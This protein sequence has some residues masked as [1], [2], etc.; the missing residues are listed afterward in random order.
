MRANHA[1]ASFLLAGLLGGL[2]FTLAVDPAWGQG[3]A[4][5]PKDA[6]KEKGRPEAK[7]GADKRDDPGP[8]K[9]AKAAA[10]DARPEAKGAAPREAPRAGE[11]K[12]AAK[13][14]PESAK[15][16]PKGGRDGA[17]DAPPAKRDA[18]DSRDKRAPEQGRDAGRDAGKAAGQAARDKAK[19]A[20]EASRDRR[21]ADRPEARRE[22]RQ[23]TN[24]DS[25]RSDVRRQ[26]REF[27]AED[28]RPADIGLW[29]NASDQGLVISDVASSGAIAR[30]GF[31]EGDRIVSVNG[32]RIT[33]EADFVRYLFAPDIR[34]QRVKVIVFR[35]GREEIVY[36][37]PVVLVQQYSVV[38]ADPLEEFG[39]VIDDRY[40][41]RLIV[42]KVIPRSP[43]FYAGI[44]AGDVIT[45]FDG[46]Q[47]GAVNDLVQLL[48]QARADEVTIGV[49]RS[50]ASRQLRVD[51]SKLR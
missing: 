25:Q 48:S 15:V 24:R 18:D 43:A 19:G 40:T 8:A 12:P 2:V 7:K 35:D 21:D 5:A 39:I 28:V 23:E 37:E 29:F 14:A 38:E 34:D 46:R 13:A 26:Q 30:V 33:R 41:D 36:V 16:A 22:T 17:N 31:R 51:V 11:P 4:D 45:T 50:Q 42:W 1:R 49:Q 20:A 47:L 10:K 6:A 32:Q 27:R 3:K 9:G 44:R